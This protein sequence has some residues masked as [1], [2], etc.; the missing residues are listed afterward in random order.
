MDELDWT[1]KTADIPAGGTE[2][3]REATAKERRTVANA[4]GI[5]QVGRLEVRYR[6]SAIAGDAYRLTGTLVADVEQACII[7]LE[8]VADRIDTHFDVEFHPDAGLEASEDEE[9]VLKGPD[10]EPLERGIIPLGRIV[11]ETL[12][13]SLDPYPRRQDAAFTWQDPRADNPEKASPFAALAT[14]KNKG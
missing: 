7:S 14:L 9:S 8:P 3:Q 13:G 10:I 1:E 12:S 11:F 6:L 2:R 4:L 5:L